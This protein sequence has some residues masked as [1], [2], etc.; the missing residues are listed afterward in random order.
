MQLIKE[1]RLRWELEWACDN[2]GVSHDGDW[3]VAPDEVRRPILAE[4]GYRRLRAE[5]PISSGGKVLRAFRNAF[6]VSIGE[7]KQSAKELTEEEGYRGTLVEVSLL[8]ELLGASG[9][10]TTID[11]A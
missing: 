1:G 11:H 3:G 7:A 4:H 8:A 5:G 2:C 6:G 9:I 10:A